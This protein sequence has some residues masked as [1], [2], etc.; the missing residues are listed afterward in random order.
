MGK[1]G[2]GLPGKY[3]MANAQVPP[4]ASVGVLLVKK[5]CV[6][7][8]IAGLCLFFHHKRSRLAFWEQ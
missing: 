5:N 4:I 2:G 1:L 6:N 8:L 3:P 7:L